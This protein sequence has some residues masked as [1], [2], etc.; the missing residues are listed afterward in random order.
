MVP[1]DRRRRGERK[2]FLEAKD[3]YRIL[4]FDPD[5]PVSESMRESIRKQL[6]RQLDALPEDGDLEWHCS[7]P[8][9]AAAIGNVV[10]SLGI[11]DVP[12]NY[13]PRK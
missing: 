11:Y 5:A 9:G 1:A 4:A 10:R 6:I 3:G 13:T 8:Y 2:V 12:A 7:D